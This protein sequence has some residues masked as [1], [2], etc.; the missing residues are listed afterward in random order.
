MKKMK[1]KRKL[2][3]LLWRTVLLVLFFPATGLGPLPAVAQQNDPGRVLN[4]VS[5]E[6]NRSVTGTVTDTHGQPLPGVSIQ[7][8][9]T[10]IGTITDAE[11]NY[12][13]AHVPEN[14]VLVFSFMGMQKQAIPV[15]GKTRLDAV[16]QETTIGI[17][18]VVAI[19]YGTLEK[20]QVTSSVSSVKADDLVDGVG[21]ASI[22]HAL[23][24]KV[25]GLIISGNGSPNS[26]NTLQLRGVASVNAGQSPLVVIDG[27][28]GGDIRS[29]IQ[30]DILSIDV[31]KDASAGAIYGTR[32]AGGVILVTTKQGQ[33]TKDGKVHLTYTGEYTFRQERD[34]P[35]VLTADEY[36]AHNRGTDYGSSADWWDELLSDH[37]NAQKHVVNVSGGNEYA[38]IYTTF[39]YKN[40]KGMAIDDE[41]T[42]YAG[43]INA[44]F[45]F[46]DGWL[47]LK[48]H[49]DYRQA[50]RNNNAPNFRQALRNNPTRSPYDAGSQ[51]GYNVW[52]NE[53]LDYNVLADSKLYDYDGLDKW[54]MPDATLKL[55]IRSVPGLSV[56]QTVG[57]EYRQW[58]L[59]TYRSKY[60]REEQE[61]DRTGTGY[62]QFSKTENLSSEG[63][64]SYIREWSKHSVNA[65]GGYSY[66]EYNSE[67][68]DMTNYNFT[69]DRVG[70]WNIGEGSYL[71]DGDASMSS[72]KAIT[73]RLFSV[74]AR[75]SYAYDDKYMLT[76]SFR[77]EGSSKFSQNNKWG[78]FW[79]VSGGWR[80][81]KEP[82][83]AGSSVVNDLKLRVG[84]GVT[85]NNSFGADY[86]ATM[87]G[88]DAYW[89]LPGGTWAYTYG[90]TKNI[91]PDLKWEEQHEWNG[92]VDYVLLN[93][94]L[95]GKFDLYRRKVKG[96]IYNVQVSQPPYVEQKMYKNIGNMENRGWEFE[97]GGEVV[98]TRD[99]KYNTSM[100]FSHNTTEIL[101]L[102]GD[103]T[104][105]DYAGFPS[106][107]NPGSA[108][109]IEE[110]A[111][112]GSFYLW[113]FAGFD[114]N[115]DF[116]LYDKDD[117]VIPAIEKTAEDKRHMGNYMPKLIVTWNHRLKYRNWDLTV[118]M[119][120]WI[121]F[122]V[123]NTIDMYFG[124]PT[125]SSE[126]NLL[127]K[128]YTKYAGVAGEKQLCDYFLEDGTFVKIDAINL[129]YSLDLKRYTGLE[130]R[131]RLYLTVG[132]VATFTGYSGIDP[133]V[134][135]TG[136]EGGIEW[137]SG[138]YPQARTYTLGVQLTF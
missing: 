115:G 84:Y 25:S 128:A 92:G 33:A 26:G 99:W 36:R 104:Y 132:N 52:L 134:N 125:R 121:D 78:D 97:I 4:A 94:R 44:N 39:M 137:F 21:G 123:Y 63:Y 76:G 110:G 68:F 48:T 108:I 27:M 42:D 136:L 54:F 34:K 91:N 46:L 64:A 11:G 69:N 61:N 12:R 55:N 1:K 138:L 3:A 118:D 120:S 88:S 28:P 71:S 13:F 100:T 133:E 57:W 129:G 41:R 135:V 56:Q 8:K 81:S 38:R 86:A 85:G 83:L 50:K 77:H 19:G 107:G 131:A 105:Y 93:N 82:F 24:G 60:H 40:D 58:E 17:D 47:E 87:Y 80:L 6:D 18:E 73:Q 117:N 114:D 112:V 102:W 89:L 43:R 51:T 2:H 75:A 90:K 72:N 29:L 31:L 79:S 101:S 106:P 22:A 35:E 59:Q 103:Q 66:Y 49:V 70:V 7:I 119:R 109:R 53:S 95:Y 126:L 74:Y 9:G 96:M 16:M 32:A 14:A 65:V 30:E 20:R 111:M 10:A 62:I 124:L 5:R 113:K 23:R 67:G 45:N 37:P 116:L 130:S 98:R 122:D 15:K 127:R